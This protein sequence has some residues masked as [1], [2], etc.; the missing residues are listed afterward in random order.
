LNN[1]LVARFAI[2]LMALGALPG[3]ATAGDLERGE[4]LYDLCQQCHGSVGQGDPMALAPAIAG[5]DEWFVTLQLQN[6]RAGIRGTHPEDVAG[7]RMHPMSRWLRTADDL[8]AVSA[9]VASLP[10]T[11]PAPT[12][13][14]GNPDKGK[15]IY[16]NCSA[17]HSADGSGNAGMKAPALRGASDWY[18]LSQLQKYKAGV[19][20]TNPGNTFGVTM[21]SMSVSLLNDEQAMKDVIAHIMTLD[22]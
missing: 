20:G 12:I 5:M 21:R 18:L 16:V 7:M 3:S 2:I 19:R 6:V 14:G 15:T 17:C 9:Y 22:N 13:E 1:H 4:Q 11:N 10:K 8:A